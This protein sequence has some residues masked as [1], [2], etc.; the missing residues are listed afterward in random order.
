M[1]L[2]VLEKKSDS[3]MLRLCRSIAEAVPGASSSVAAVSQ[4]GASRL[5]AAFIRGGAP[6]PPAGL[7][8]LSAL[9]DNPGASKTVRNCV[10]LLMLRS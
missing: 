4:T 10:C 3:E 8:S 1:I 5:Y 2:K 7:L 6:V 9:S